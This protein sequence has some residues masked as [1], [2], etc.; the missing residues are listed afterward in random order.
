MRGAQES[1]DDNERGNSCFRRYSVCLVA[2]RDGRERERDMVK[3]MEEET[4]RR[5][6][7]KE[8]KEDHETRLNGIR[9]HFEVDLWNANKSPLLQ[10][11]G[12]Q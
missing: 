2:V 9:K 6:G 7:R 1:Q 5:W 12:H 8:E 3:I 10:G 4:V 11:G